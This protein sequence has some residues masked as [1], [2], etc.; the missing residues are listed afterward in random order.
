MKSSKRFLCRLVAMALALCCIF[1]LS[2]NALAAGNKIGDIDGNG[3]VDLDDV[4]YLLLHVM[5]GEENYPLNPPTDPKPPVNTDG[6]KKLSIGLCQ[7]YKVLSY[8]DNELTKLLEEK[9]GVDIEFWPFAAGQADARQQ[10]ALMIAGGQKLPD[11]IVGFLDDAMRSKLGQEGYLIDCTPFLKDPNYFH[12]GSQYLAVASETEKKLFWDVCKDPVTGAIYGIPSLSNGGA[13]DIC[14]YLGGIN[15]AFAEKFGMDP[16]K[17]DT[18]EEVHEYLT[19]VVNGDPNGNGKK[20]EMGILYFPNGNRSNIEQW[21]VNAYIYWNEGSFFNI[22][23]GEVWEPYTTQEFREAY[24]VMNQWYKEGLICD[25]SFTIRTAAEMKVLLDTPEC[26]TI[27]IFGGHPTVVLDSK[28]TLAET[29]TNL[30]V[31]Q[32]ETEKGGY[33]VLRSNNVVSVNVSITKDCKNPELAFKFLDHNLNPELGPIFRYGEEGVNWVKVNGEITTDS[34]E[35]VKVF[36]ETGYPA[37]YH[38]IKDEWSTETK[39]TW[40]TMMNTMWV[41]AGYENGLGC[42]PGYGGFAYYFEPGTRNELTW[43]NALEMKSG[44]EPAEKFFNISYNTAEKEIVT[45]VQAE[46][47]DTLN[48]WRAEFITGVKDPNNDAHWEAFV[49]DLEEAGIYFWLDVAQDAYDRL[50]GL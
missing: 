9:T 49:D 5:F 50:M 11:I 4:V 6:S 39:A 37:G 28:S 34:G 35:T 15:G 30:Q 25:L 29:Y 24:K 20:D 31:L 43:N 45:E 13:V 36:D 40:H 38:V 8:D 22:T 14:G 33:T 44:K 47:I 26:Y 21:I 10:L 23:D 1:S 3:V 42:N 18:V 16:A 46:V 32:P 2:G 17:I 41:E 27:G 7:N 12:Y 19:K 48:T